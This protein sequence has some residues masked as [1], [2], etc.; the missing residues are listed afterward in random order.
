MSLS[1]LQVDHLLR[2]SVPG[3]TVYLIGVGGCGM[4]GL[5]HLLLDL[6]YRVVG[7]DLHDNPE[8][9]QL[10]ARGAHVFIGHTAGQ[11]NAA[12]PVLVVR[13]SAVRED[14]PEWMAAAAQ[15]IPVV[16]RAVLLATLLHRQRG[17][18]VAG[19]HGKTTTSSLLAYT[20]EQLSAHPSYA[21]GWQ[22]PQF[23]RPARLVPA[24]DPS[25]PPFFVIEADESDGT[26]CQF[27]PE[28]AIL[29]NIDEEHLDHFGTFADIQREF[30]QFTAQ[31][32][33]DVVYCADDPRLSALLAAH[34]RGVTYGYHPMAQYRI[35]NVESGA[36]GRASRFE[37]CC[38]GK[39]QGVFTTSLL[40]AKNISN[41]AAVVAL[42][43]RFGFSP[44]AV[45][46]A[47][48][49]FRGAS[50]RQQELFA[51]DGI[52]VY[53]DYGHHPSEIR[54]TLAAV[55][56]LGS[57]RL[58]VAFQPHRYTRTRL[59]MREFAD[60]FTGADRLWLTDIYP[61]SEPPIPG[62]TSGVL[63]QTIREG[64]Q[65]VEYVASFAEL[66]ERV[67]AELQ[68]GDLVLFLGAGG[69]ITRVAHQLAERLRQRH[70]V[71]RT[72]GGA[73]SAGDR[74]AAHRETVLT[75]VV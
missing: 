61:A 7:S 17:I 64:G 51:D 75:T 37:I 14:N 66:Q 2:Q 6:G 43:L 69:D 8:V 11:I 56:A 45:A 44:A 3:A 33:G 1:T 18:C 35:L 9:E 63:A 34:P 41:A 46:A 19:M 5:G 24:P 28:H 60:C 70:A 21:I 55:R 54:A 30:E 68:A 71:G 50:R 25:A 65:T 59:L 58:L 29:L 72:D 39:S 62:V 53:D 52:R 31:V 32:R 49:G 15:G 20:L 38:R 26:L 57:R 40:G 12:R 4:S 10:R 22:V 47:L 48:A 27:H 74:P 73:A 16:R 13:T 23:D 36:G 42:T 67:D